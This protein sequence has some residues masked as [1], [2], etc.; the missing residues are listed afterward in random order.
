MKKRAQK[1]TTDLCKCTSAKDEQLTPTRPNDRPIA[2]RRGNDP[3]I[4]P[5]GNS[6][7]NSNRK[8]GGDRPL[9]KNRSPSLTATGRQDV[10]TNHHPRNAGNSPER[11]ASHY[12]PLFNHFAQGRRSEFLTP[13]DATLIYPWSGGRR[14]NKCLPAHSTFAGHV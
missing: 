9:K 2:K 7:L 8:K 5:S 1:Q 6:L 3:P 11:R 13:L 14:V 4:R 12:N 10:F